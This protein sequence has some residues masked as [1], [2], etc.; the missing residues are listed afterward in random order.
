MDPTE[1]VLPEHGE[2][3]Q[4][5]KLCVLKYKQDGILDKKHYDG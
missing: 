3:I 2:R 5:P 1:K 4:S